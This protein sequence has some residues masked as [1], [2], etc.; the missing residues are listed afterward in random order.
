MTSATFY[1]PLGDGRFAATEHTRGPWSDQHQHGGPPAALL[2]HGMEALLPAGVQLARITFELPRPVPIA[3]LQLR[4]EVVRA[5]RAVTTL[6]AALT[7]V[8]D[9]TEVMGSPNPGYWGKVTVILGKD[10]DGSAFP[11][12]GDTVTLGRER[13][14]INFPEDGY[15]SG[16]HA[17][18]TNR[19]REAERE[20]DPGNPL[21][22]LEEIR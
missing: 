22:A 2:A 13:G 8:A 6:T 16:L 9:G 17:R 14:E 15:V 4:A 12:L 18:V 20:R 3:D 7:T 21:F 10:I 11:L 5:G 1:L 19:K